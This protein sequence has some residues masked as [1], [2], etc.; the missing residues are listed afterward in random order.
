MLLLYASE[1]SSV[2]ELAQ[3]LGYKPK[4]TVPAITKVDVYHVVPSIGSGINNAPDLRY[5][6]IIKPGLQLGVEGNS[7]LLFRSKDEVNFQVSS[8]YDPI[9]ISIYSI[10]SN[11]P[12]YYLLKKSVT[13]ESGAQKSIDF[14][15]TTPE[16]YK[17]ITLSDT[18]IISID[19]VVDSAGNIW[20]EVPYLSQDTIFA[21]HQYIANQPY[22]LKLQK[23]SKRFIT[24]YNSDNTLSI[25]FGS[26]VVSN[27]DEE[28]TPN[29]DNIG[30]MTPGGITKLND[31]WDMANFMF[32]DAYGESPSNTTLTITYTIGGGIKSNALSNTI[33]SIRNIEYSNDLASLDQNVFNLVKNSIAVANPLA[34]TGGRDFESIDEIRHNALAY[35]AAQDRVVTKDDFL[36]RALAMPAKYGSISKSYVEQSKDSLVLNLYTLSYDANKKLTRTNEIVKRNLSV[37]LDK[38]RM[39]TD[40]IVLRDAYIVNFGISYDLYVSPGFNV[41]EVMLN[42]INELKKYFDIDKWQINQPIII[43]EIYKLLAVISGVQN[44]INIQVNNLF[45]IYSGYSPTVYDLNSATKDNIIY[46][47]MDPCIFEIKYPDVDIKCRIK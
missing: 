12:N 32:T 11:E 21:E 6:L 10:Q 41:N 18:N 7:S 1:R 13:V 5:G 33:N 42:T 4:P 17:K 24:R 3:A 43:S 44:I 34:A 8:S 31:S 22:L 29:P 16:R 2:V 14:T 38:Y 15:F 27:N 37:Y 46:P 20:Y 36:L 23:V 19:K 26:G 35:F 40:T 9:E 47:S 39:L 45:D 28:I 25:Q 30:L